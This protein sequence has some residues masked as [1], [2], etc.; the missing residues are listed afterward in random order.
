MFIGFKYLPA[1][2][3]GFARIIGS[4]VETTYTTWEE[5]H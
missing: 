3:Q 2:A 5:K 1:Q 4:G